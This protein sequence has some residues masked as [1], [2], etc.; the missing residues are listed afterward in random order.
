MVSSKERIQ[1]SRCA[2]TRDAS[3]DGHYLNRHPQPAVSYEDLN[4]KELLAACPLEGID[5]T[6]ER[7]IPR[8]ADV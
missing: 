6:R 8:N 3:Q 2:G 5:L 4:F 7:E 1:E